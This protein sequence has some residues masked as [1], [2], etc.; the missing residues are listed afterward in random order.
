M[1]A[2]LADRPTTLVWEPPFGAHADGGVPIT[3]Y[4]VEWWTQRAINDV[5]LG[6]YPP[7]SYPIAQLGVFSRA[8]TSTP[9]GG[10]V[11]NAMPWTISPYDLRSELLNMGYRDLNSTAGALLG[12]IQ[13]DKTDI[14]QKGYQWR[15]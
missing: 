9:D 14:L 1:S 7:P 13:V 12:D 10:E 4:L 6:Q 11:T 15:V 3:G 8:F 5:Q 2:P